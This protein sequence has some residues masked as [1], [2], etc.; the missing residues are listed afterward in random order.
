MGSTVI[1]KLHS[2]FV[3]EDYT[4]VLSVNCSVDHSAIFKTKY[5]NKIVQK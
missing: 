4:S 3:I 1:Q 5:Y 2:V